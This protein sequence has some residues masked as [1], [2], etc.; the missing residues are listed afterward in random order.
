MIW[1]HVGGCVNVMDAV[2]SVN[3]VTIQELG[4]ATFSVD[5][6]GGVPNISPFV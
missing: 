2:G 4:V 5:E 1:V 6:I 3:V